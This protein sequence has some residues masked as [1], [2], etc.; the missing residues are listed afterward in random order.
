MTGKECEDNDAAGRRCPK[1]SRAIDTMFSFDDADLAAAFEPGGLDFP[2]F[3]DVAV[4]AQVLQQIVLG[5]VV[6]AHGCPL[7]GAILYQNA[8]L[9]FDPFSEEMR[10]T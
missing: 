10:V 2:G 3:R 6:P 7:H 8:F 5:D 9:A 1:R 4:Q